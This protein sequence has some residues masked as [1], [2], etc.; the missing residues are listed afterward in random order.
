MSIQES[1]LYFKQDG[2]DK[3]YHAQIVEQEPGYVVN[4]QFGRRGS[5]LTPGTKTKVPVTYDDAIK[6]FDKLVKEKKGKGYTEG[7]SGTPYVGGD[8]E[9]RVSG[10]QVQ[11]LN[12]VNETVLA[13]LL[14]DEHFV[15]QEK[16]DGKRMLL[17]FD[18][19]QA[20]AINRKGLSCGAPQ[21]ILDEF[22][23]QCEISPTETVIDGECIGDLFHAFDVLVFHGEDIRGRGFLSRFQLLE[24]LIDPEGGPIVVGM[25]VRNGKKVFFEQ[26]KATNREGIVLKH[27]EAPYTPGRPASGGTQFKFKFQETATCEVLKINSAKRSF[28]VGLRDT[29]GELTFVGSVAVPANKDF[30]EPGQ[31]VEVRY[32][33]AFEGGSIYQPFFIGVRDDKSEADALASLKFKAV[34]V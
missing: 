21:P 17:R 34:T 11:L 33:Y 2:S 1:N 6:L 20:T 9:D 8:K 15:A 12:P 29:E 32:L 16:F 7:E 4:F 26:L 25:C 30:P 14:N 13:R 10:Y 5:T 23:A 28:E 27:L 19:L 24:S 22:R 18:G 31:M 3:V